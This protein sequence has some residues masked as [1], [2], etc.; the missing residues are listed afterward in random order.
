MTPEAPWPPK[1]AGQLR[2]KHYWPGSLSSDLTDAGTDDSVS[3]SG[4]K[5]RIPHSMHLQTNRR[6]LGETLTETEKTDQRFGADHA[7]HN[8]AFV[9]EPENLPSTVPS[10]ALVPYRK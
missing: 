3:I 1:L 9:D 10:M 7:T 4:S 2:N 8:G 6:D 5:H